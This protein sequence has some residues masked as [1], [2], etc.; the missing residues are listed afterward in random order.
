L[1]GVGGRYFED[2]AEASVRDKR[3]APLHGVAPF[4][5]DADNARRLWTVS[6][7]LLAEVN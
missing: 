3:G 6:E 1:N 4:A 2:C 5:L 7:A